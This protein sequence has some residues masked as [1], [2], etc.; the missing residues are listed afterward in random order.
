MTDL[1]T[2][3]KCQMRGCRLWFSETSYRLRCFQCLT[4]TPHTCL[5]NRIYADGL[6]YAPAVPNSKG[7]FH[8]PVFVLPIWHYLPLIAY[9]K[10][11]WGLPGKHRRRTRRIMARYL[12]ALRQDA[13]RSD[14]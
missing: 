11:R 1:Y 6:R 4:Q 9:P 5:G 3:D 12:E 8:N 10:P 7:H 2:C 13:L 14:D